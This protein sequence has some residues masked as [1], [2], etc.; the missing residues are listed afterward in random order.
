MNLWLAFITAWLEACRINTAPD[1]SA[2]LAL[3]RHRMLLRVGE[4]F[5]KTTL[6]GFRKQRAH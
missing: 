4:V 6:Q 5:G 2:R 1:G 3:I